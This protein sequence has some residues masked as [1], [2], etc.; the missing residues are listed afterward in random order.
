MSLPRAIGSP[1]DLGTVLLRTVGQP[2][3]FGTPLVVWQRI[4]NSL[5]SEH[6]IKVW[7]KPEFD[8]CFE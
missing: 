6:G 1:T 8:V 4:K 2:T 7:S 3:I 5:S